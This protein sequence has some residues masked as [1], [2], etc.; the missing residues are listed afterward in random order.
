MAT[1]MAHGFVQFWSIKMGISR[2]Q[3]AYIGTMGRKNNKLL[4]YFIT[5]GYT[6]FQLHNN[7]K[8]VTLRSYGENQN[9]LHVIFQNNVFLFIERLSSREAKE[10]KMFLNRVRRNNNKPSKGHVKDGAIIVSTVTPNKINKNSFQEVDNEPSSESFETGEGSGTPASKSSTLT[11]NDLPESGHGKKKR[12]LPS[13]SKAAGKF[14]KKTSSV[15]DEKSKKNPLKHVIHNKKNQLRLTLLKS[16][17]LT[18]EHL[19]NTSSIGNLYLYDSSLLLKFFEKV[20]LRFLLAEKYNVPKSEWESFKTTLEFYP[21]KLLQGFPNLGN[22]C[23]MN[24]IL[25]TLFLIPTFVDDLFSKDFPW[26]KIPL[27]ALSICLA[28]LFVFRDIPDIKIKKRLLVN[29]K[30]TVSSMAKVFSSNGQNDAHEFLSHCLD[31]TKENMKKLNIIWKATIESE[32]ENP[33]QQIFAGSAATRV[34]VCPIIS[35][36]EFELLVSITCQSCG[37]AVLK[38]EVNNY[39]SINLPQGMS[40]PLSIISAFNFYFTSELLAYTCEKC[41]HTKSVLRHEFSRLPRVLIVHLK[42]SIFGELWL[43]K[44]DNQKVL[45]PTCLAVSPYC[46]ES[47]E[48]PFP[49]SKDVLT[50]EFQILKVFESMNSENDFLSTYSRKLTLASNDSLIPHIGPDKESE[51]QKSQ[52]LCEESEGKQKEDLGKCPKLNIR[53]SEL[54]NLGEEAVT[55][56]ELSAADLMTDLEAT[57][58]SQIQEDEGKPTSGPDKY[59]AE[60]YLQEMFENLKRKKDETTNILVDFKSGTETTEDFY[61]R[62]KRVPKEFQKLTEET[63]QGDWMKTYEETLQ[64]TLSRT[65]EKPHAQ[66]YGENLRRPAELSIQKASEKSLGA[67]GSNKNSENK[68]FL[69]EE[70]SETEATNLE[71]NAEMSDLHTYRLIAV[72]SHLGKSRNSGH[73]ISDVYDFESQMWFTYDDLEVLSIPEHVMQKARL[74]T[75]YIFFYMH[76]DIFEELLKREKNFQSLNTEAGKS[77]QEE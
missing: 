10:L 2:P 27:H 70:K 19:F 59:L 67:S 13:G 17:K 42:R 43:L 7:I 26:G 41:Q 4:V 64:Q 61:R 22:T 75:G 53:E 50:R 46:S 12:V 9:N 1:V 15:R 48:P 58:L 49:V 62:E 11:C 52:N 32:A 5:G 54:V 44:K 63:Q 76:N 71:S 74:C 24:T 25:Q 73:Y 20:Y 16:K 77:P 45:I 28:Q 60:V 34:L 30:N 72:V 40:P 65:L 33:A 66:G 3:E 39:L 23:Y 57:S 8:N 47:T 21:E 37:N 6:T 68:E 51:P 35:N 14:L 31:Q 38:T 29:V 55:K 56:K 18:F 36:F 69:D